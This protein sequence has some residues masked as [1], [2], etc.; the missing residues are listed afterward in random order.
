[1]QNK[2]DNYLVIYSEDFEKLNK[3]I[4]AYNTINTNIS[5][6][7]IGWHI[8]HTLLA[9]NDYIETLVKSNP[10]EYKWKFNFIRY[11]VLFTK[12]IPRGF[13]KSPEIL[14]PK[15]HN[16]AESLEK[17]LVETQNNINEF[18]KISTNKF[19]EHPVFGQLKLIDTLNF[20]DTHTKHHLKIIDDILSKDEYLNDKQKNI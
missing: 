20:L 7:S 8:E 6:A 19:I 17:Y 3:K 18:K 15:N 1:M 5:K 13:G 9:F 2:I 16:T 10:E 12:L 14:V 11:V 4:P